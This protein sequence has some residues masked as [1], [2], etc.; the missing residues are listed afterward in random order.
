MTAV[1][2]GPVEVCDDH[3]ERSDAASPEALDTP[4]TV[5]VDVAEPTLEA[6]FS[7]GD[8]TLAMANDETGHEALLR[9]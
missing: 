8:S 4:L 1:R 6:G 7:D 3:S 2:R 5:G 9:A